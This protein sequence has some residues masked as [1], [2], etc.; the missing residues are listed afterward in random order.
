MFF[1]DDFN[2]LQNVPKKQ[3]QSPPMASLIGAYICLKF[4]MTI[5]EKSIASRH[6]DFSKVKVKEYDWQRK[7]K[8]EIMLCYCRW[9]WLQ[10]ANIGKG[11]SCHREKKA[12]AVLADGGKHRQRQNQ[13]QRHQNKHGLLTYFCLMVENVMVCSGVVT[14]DHAHRC[15]I[16]IYMYRNHVMNSSSRKSLLL[17]LL[18]KYT[19]VWTISP[20]LS[21]KKHLQQKSF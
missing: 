2:V 19:L 11:S 13:F 15:V 20:R 5:Y 10:L 21:F 16:Y 14:N 17:F 12:W 7:S 9:H 6:R 1:I 3:G 4:C 8:K 18:I